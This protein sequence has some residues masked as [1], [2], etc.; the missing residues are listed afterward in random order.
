MAASAPRR[1]RRPGRAVAARGRSERRLWPAAGV[2][3]GT[4]IALVVAAAGVFGSAAPMPPPDSDAAGALELSAADA[5]GSSRTEASSAPVE[6]DADPLLTATPDPH[7]EAGGL[8]AGFPSDLIPVP[9]DAIILVTSAAPVGDADV[10]E[11]SLNLHTRMTTT[12]VVELYRN[13]LVTAG[14]TEVDA[15]DSALDADASFSRAGGDELVVLGVL[16]DG[17]SRTVTI[18]GRVRDAG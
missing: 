14:F 15:T 10:Q 5:P 2:L 3:A 11:V 17:T 16:D 12:Q 4:A 7:S 1:A 8:V 13:A 18:G 9:A 6:R